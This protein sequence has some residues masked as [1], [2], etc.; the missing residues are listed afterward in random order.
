MAL[1]GILIL[2]SMCLNL[3]YWDEYK[4]QL[5]MIFLACS[6][7]FLAGILK[8]SEPDISYELTRKQLCFY[9]R[10]GN[11][12]INWQ[13]IARLDQP[14]ANNIF[15]KISLP[16]VGIKLKDIALIADN[17]SPRLANKLIHEQRELLILAAKNNEIKLDSGLISFEPFTLNKKTY[18]GPIAAWLFRTEQLNQVYG[19]HLFLPETGFDRDL[20]D[21]LNLL[22]QCKQ[23]AVKT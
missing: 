11:W 6:I 14:S 2:I 17:I 20:D 23:Y 3:L 21:F 13:D 8:H 16:Y 12:K 15:E 22:K 1:G 18:K 4:I 9:H 5:M 10:T 19:Y 7:V